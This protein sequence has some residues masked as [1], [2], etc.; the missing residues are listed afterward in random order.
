MHAFVALFY[1]QAALTPLILSNTIQ[2]FI[3]AHSSYAY[4][5]NLMN[6]FF[7]DVTAN[8]IYITLRVAKYNRDLLIVT[9]LPNFNCKSLSD[10]LTR[11]LPHKINYFGA[12]KILSGRIKADSPKP[13]HFSVN[14]LS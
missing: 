3:L 11:L 7:G 1:L 9:K 4:C 6:Q 14:R 13:L 8:Y 10:V 5:K 2:T 12:C